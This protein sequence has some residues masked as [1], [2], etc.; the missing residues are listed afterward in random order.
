M[1]RRLPRAF[2]DEPTKSDPWELWDDALVAGYNSATGYLLND[3]GKIIGYIAAPITDSP[4]PR[5]DVQ[6]IPRP[7]SHPARRV[8]TY[9]A[10][11]TAEES[12]ETT[13]QRFGIPLPGCAG[14]THFTNLISAGYR[15]A[16][17]GPGDGT[18][19]EDGT[20]GTRSLNSSEL[21]F[22]VLIQRELDQIRW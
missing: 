22:G 13:L 7:A 17:I 18:D 14:S 21:D 9:V 5:P 10:G 16:R 8:A 11:M 6:S 1:T 2:V 4:R 12:W 20:K 19:F 15:D 3:H